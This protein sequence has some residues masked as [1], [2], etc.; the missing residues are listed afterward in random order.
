[1]AS[2]SKDAGSGNFHIHFRFGGKL[3]HKSLKTKDETK[4]KSWAGNIAETLHDLERGKLV[5]PHGANLWEFLKTNGQREQKLQAPVHM[6]LGG[7]FD[8]YFASLPE[9][10]KDS[11][12]IKV[13]TVHANHFKRLLK[14]TTELAAITGQVLQTEYV[15]NRVKEKRYGKPIS[16]QTIKKEIDTLRMVWNQA[17][18]KKAPG[19]AGPCPCADLVYPPRKDP[20][21]FQTWAQIEEAIAGGE[22]TEDQK[23]EQWNSLFLDLEQVA[24]FLAHVRQKHTRRRYFYPLMVFVAYTGARISECR[25]SQLSDLDF[26]GMKVRIRERKKKQGTE[27]FRWVRMSPFLRDVMQEWRERDHPGGSYT[28]CRFAGKKFHEQTLH[29]DFEWFVKGTKWEVLKGFHVFRHSFASNL[30]REGVD[31]G[32]IDELMGHQTEEMRKRYHHLFPEQ[33]EDAIKRLFG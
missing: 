26:E 28:F 18:R 9:G 32:V 17:F 6:T 29:D 1:M 16:S 30:A 12:T 21:P 33:K 8:W 24:E 5:L 3:F 31:R 11:K 14:P 10:S 27:T 22:W 25:R 23:R 19:V 2:L 20:A 13:L 4:A 15:N 7:L